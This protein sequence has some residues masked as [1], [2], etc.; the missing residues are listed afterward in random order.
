MTKDILYLGSK[1][2]PRQRLVEL[3]G[4]EYRLLEHK[5][6]EC[7][8]DLE[9]NFDEYVLSIAQ[10]KMQHLI[11]PDGYQGEEIFVLT[12]DTLPRAGD[13]KH[14]LG[15]PEDIAQAKEW[16]KLLAQGE[17]EVVTGCCL[18][19]RVYKNGV[20]EL[21]DKNHWIT[22]SLVEFFVDSDSIDWYLQKTPN[23]LNASGAAI[24][25][26]FG[27]CF[28][29]SVNGS[30]TNILG[31]PLFELRHALKEMGFRFAISS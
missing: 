2:K 22:K 6:D 25:E 30:Y 8:I 20:W 9:D 13:G 23:V 4:V 29:K 28:L 17:A 1:S 3:A 7:G 26:E 12:A 21:K 14:V 10:D 31:L 16:L 19:K 24:I 18:E 11:F 5:S 15:K 27:Q